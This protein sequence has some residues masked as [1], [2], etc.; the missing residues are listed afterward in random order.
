M[1]QEKPRRENL[2]KRALYL[3]LHRKIKYTF[4]TE[5]SRLIFYR[6]FSISVPQLCLE[7]RASNLLYGTVR[8]VL[9]FCAC[10]EI[11]TVRTVQNSIPTSKNVMF[12]SS[13]IMS[14]LFCTVASICVPISIVRLSR[15]ACCTVS[16]FWT[17]FSANSLSRFACR[18]F[19][20]GFMQIPNSEICPLSSTSSEILLLSSFLFTLRSCSF[21]LHPQLA[22]KE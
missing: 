20:L 4:S 14:T 18:K 2:L 12:L 7:N 22:F 3:S 21:C 9:D 8:T 16:Q 5:N 13:K 11:R 1:T 6:N 15:F 17:E 10:T 19:L